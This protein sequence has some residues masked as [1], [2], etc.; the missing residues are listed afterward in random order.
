MNY[1]S[2][3]FVCQRNARF[4]HS[5]YSLSV[6]RVKETIKR[7]RTQELILVM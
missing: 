4:R 7:R 5:S 2:F 3:V 1:F 6:Q